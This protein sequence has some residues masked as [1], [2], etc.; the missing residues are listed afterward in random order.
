MW[1]QGG[2]ARAAKKWHHCTTSEKQ[3]AKPQHVSLPV[4]PRALPLSGCQ[5]QGQSERTKSGAC[6]QRGAGDVATHKFPPC[7]RRAH[8][9]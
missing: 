5:K 7:Q 8:Q 3:E 9:P 1:R 6:G 4:H 2:D